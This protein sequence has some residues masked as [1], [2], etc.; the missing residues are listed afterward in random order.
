MLLTTL[1]TD[2]PVA[3][4]VEVEVALLACLAAHSASTTSAAHAWRNWSKCMAQRS[5]RNIIM[6]KTARIY[7]AKTKGYCCC[8]SF[9]C[10]CIARTNLCVVEAKVI[11]A[12]QL[13]R[14]AVLKQLIAFDL[15]LA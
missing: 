9:C 5:L 4:S 6:S 14:F 15:Q 2:V 7:N 1:V 12:M 3:A 8:I 10:R 11:D 13:Q